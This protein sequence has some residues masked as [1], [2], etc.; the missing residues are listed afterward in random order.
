IQ[1]IPASMLVVGGGVIGCEYACIFA[2]LGVKVTV[3]EKRNL[4]V[5]G[6]DR[7]ISESLKEQ[8]EAARIDFVMNDEVAGVTPGAEVELH[9][10]SGQ[11]LKAEAILVS[12]GR[13]GQTGTLGLDRIGVQTNERGQ[14][15]VNDSYQT[16]VSHIYAAGDV[17]GYPSL[18]S[19][20]MEQ[21]RLAM[22]H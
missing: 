2:A 4:I 9:L 21:A 12:S 13:C 8:M 15:E 16:A 1:D 17:I 11:T 18:A 3:I 5:G 14:I 22:V 10:K 20:S 19:T 6:M 7:E